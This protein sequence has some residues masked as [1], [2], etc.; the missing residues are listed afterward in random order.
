V[1]HLHRGY[2]EGVEQLYEQ[3]VRALLKE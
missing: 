1:R 2:K 3:Q